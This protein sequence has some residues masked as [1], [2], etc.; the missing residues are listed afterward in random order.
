MRTIDP[1]KKHRKQ[2]RF[3]PLQR[4]SFS[5]SSLLL[6]SSS[7]SSSSCF[8]LICFL[9]PAARSCCESHGWP[10]ARRAGY[11]RPPWQRR[12]ARCAC[13]SARRLARRR[14]LRTS[15]PWRRRAAGWWLR[16]WTWPR[17][18]RRNWRPR[19]STYLCWRCTARVSPPTM[20][21]VQEIK[22]KDDGRK[23]AQGEHKH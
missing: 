18:R 10:R 1:K 20:P 4:C 6:L 2:K 13:S 21:P 17:S 7:S 8:S 9:A 3:L 15:S 5:D 14:P 23:K 12:R 16:P 11:T 22:G 19:R